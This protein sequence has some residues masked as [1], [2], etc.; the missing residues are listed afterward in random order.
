MII[1]SFVPAKLAEHDSNNTSYTTSYDNAAAEGPRRKSLAWLTIL[2]R[3]GD[4]ERFTNA[5]SSPSPCYREAA[6]YIRR[7]D[8][9]KQ[10][11]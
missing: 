6:G 5:A 10:A 9:L 1:A 4:S 8:S 3:I 7:R 2:C 11:S